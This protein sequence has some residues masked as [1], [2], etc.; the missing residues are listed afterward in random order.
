MARRLG[1]SRQ[2]VVD[3]AVRVVDDHG[4]DA[5]TVAA[6]AGQVGCRPPSVYHHVDGLDGLVRAVALVG[7][8][9]LRET[10]GG[11][12]GGVPALL[13]AALDYASHRGG[14]FDAV[15]RAVPPDTDEELVEARRAVLDTVRHALA[16]HGAPGLD[17]DEWLVVATA[18][19]RGLVAVERVRE[20]G[21]DA[22]R[23]A[24]RSA[25]VGAVA[26][27]AEGSGVLATSRA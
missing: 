23:A 8:Q 7:A 26:A 4:L 10:L 22:A 14:R 24:A 25:L 9:D 16:E 6:V 21:D 19:V 18:A 12:S 20:P 2:D 1:V 15:L 13:E 3:A 27:A 11:A 17:V 5:L